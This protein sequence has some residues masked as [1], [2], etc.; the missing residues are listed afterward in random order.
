MRQAWAF[1]TTFVYMPRAEA[2]SGSGGG[3]RLRLSD[4]DVL[5]ASTVII[6]TGVTYRRLGIP[7]LEDL[8]GRGVF[9]GAAASEA[10]AMRGQT[11]FVAGTAQLRR[12]GR[13]APG[14]MG[15]PGDSPGPRG[16]ADGQHVRLPHPRDRLGA[17]RGRLLPRAGRQRHRRRPSRI[18]GPGRRRLRGAP[19][20][21]G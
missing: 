19:Q 8:Q 12:A 18:A 15:Q 2:L 13:A 16:I 14:Q 5:T 11:V 17:E 21:P 20:R 9:D 4:G 10:P 7:A 6:A 3:Y 1:G